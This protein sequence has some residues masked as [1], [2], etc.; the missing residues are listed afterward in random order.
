MALLPKPSPP[1]TL[2]LSISSSTV[3]HM[4]STT[5]SESIPNF[6]MSPN[7]HGRSFIKITH[8]SRLSNL[9][10]FRTYHSLGPSIE[11]AKWGTQETWQQEILPLRAMREKGP[12]L[13]SLICYSSHGFLSTS[14]R[15]PNIYL[16]SP[17]DW[18]PSYY[19]KFFLALLI[20]SNYWCYILRFS[21]F[22]N[23]LKI[24]L[25]HFDIIFESFESFVS[26]NLTWAR[27][28]R[29]VNPSDEFFSY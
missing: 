9:V 17:L 23:A 4:H 6:H 7:C 16:E 13:F 14:K 20:F 27:L 1:A 26:N 25:Y 12:W 3:T 28:T 2:P 21:P 24:E 29:F 5:H 19:S 22:F 10:I 15:W 11:W 18:F 8:S